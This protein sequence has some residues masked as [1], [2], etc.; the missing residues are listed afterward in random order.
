M[1]PMNNKSCVVLSILIMTL[2]T[3]SFLNAQYFELASPEIRVW[4]D[5]IVVKRNT[6]EARG[7]VFMHQSP[8]TIYAGYIKLDLQTKMLVADKTVLA[9]FKDACLTGNHLRLDLN[10]Q[11]GIIHQG[12]FFYEPGPLYLKGNRIEKTG[13][14][15]YYVDDVLVTG[16][17]ICDPDWSITG[18]DVH[19]TIDGYARLWHGKMF[20]KNMPVFYTPFF[21]FPVKKERQSGLLFPFVEQSLRKGWLYQQPFYMVLGQRFDATLYTTYMEKR[22]IMN[23]LEFRYNTGD[24]N[25]GTVMVDYLDDRQQETCS[26]HSQWGY[27]H[28]H[29]LRSNADRYWFRMKLDQPL[30][31]NTMAKLDIDWVSDPDYL[32][33]FDTSYTG[34]EQ[35]RKSLF[36]RHHRTIDDS[37]ETIRSNRLLIYRKFDFSRIYGEFQ[38]FDD[39]YHRKLDLDPSPIHQLPVIR[40]SSIQSPL[41]QL[42]IFLNFDTQYA[43]DYQENA[44]NRHNL[45]MASGMTLPVDI[46]PFAVI[47]PSFHI[48]GGYSHSS[49]ER[50]STHQKIIKTAITSE[51]YK[52]YSFGLNRANRKVKRNSST[53]S[54][55]M[56][57]I[58]IAQIL[59]K[60]SISFICSVKNQTRFIG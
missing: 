14:N 52:I 50:K 19:I 31:F 43:Y 55:F 9:Q 58:H 25:T 56:L 2:G 40:F 1:K 59:M 38:W 8:L 5:Q 46:L 54:A 30:I 27:D 12:T 41:W 39:V 47:E 13:P 6:V 49:F 34:F 45:Y 28:D 21:I 36:D 15:S 23:G 10:T 7:D 22:G 20:V 32:K 35:S 26:N 53:L 57:H 3:S 44:H 4:A 16:C 51:L 48:K 42:P 17:D 33:T 24:D 37:D 60:I 11:N 18:K 29:Y